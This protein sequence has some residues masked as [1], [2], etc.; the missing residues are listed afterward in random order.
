MKSSLDV[1][2]A[3]EQRRGTVERGKS[4]QGREFSIHGFIDCYGAGEAL[5][6][7][8][9]PVA[10]QERP[11]MSFGG[12]LAVNQTLEDGNFPTINIMTRSWQ[13]ILRDGATYYTGATLIIVATGPTT[14]GYTAHWQAT[15]KA[16]V[17]PL[18]DAGSASSVI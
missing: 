13:T 8:N 2:R 5:Q 4:I 11:A 3:M 9:F 16:L 10:F 1:S 6:D 15:G 12:E 14:M 17:N 7:V 18:N